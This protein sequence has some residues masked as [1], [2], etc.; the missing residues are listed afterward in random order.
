MSIAA[1]N[2]S[3]AELTRAQTREPEER[4]RLRRSS[5]SAAEWRFPALVHLPAGLQSSFVAERSPRKWN[6]CPPCRRFLPHPRWAFPSDRQAAFQQPL[7]CCGLIKM[8]KSSQAAD[9]RKQCDPLHRPLP[10]FPLWH[11]GRAD[12]LVPLPKPRDH[13]YP[14]GGRWT[15]RPHFLQCCLRNDAK[16][17]Q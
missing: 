12:L 13:A 9:Q 2:Q 16:S 15:Y 1:S 4:A 6:T 8:R 3:S 11:R 5:S 7:A 14:L 10:S 17:R